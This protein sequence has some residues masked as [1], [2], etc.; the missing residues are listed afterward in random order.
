M[1]FDESLGVYE[2]VPEYIHEPCILKIA[3]RLSRFL[4][5]T[6]DETE[7]HACREKRQQR[8]WPAAK[9]LLV[10]TILGTKPEILVHHNRD[11]PRAPERAL[12]SSKIPAPMMFQSRTLKTCTISTPTFSDALPVIHECNLNLFRTRSSYSNPGHSSK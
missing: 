4:D 11:C 5:R 7:H 2:A 9:P 12:D 10:T 3:L 6:R 1:I 8:K